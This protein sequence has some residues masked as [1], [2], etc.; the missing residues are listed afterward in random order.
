MA[1]QATMMHLLLLH[2]QSPQASQR[3]FSSYRK[4]PGYIAALSETARLE[5]V[6]YI[7]INRCPANGWVSA[8]W[9]F[10]PTI[11]EFGLQDAHERSGVRSVFC[12]VKGEWLPRCPSLV[13]GPRLGLPDSRF[14][15]SVSLGEF[16][17]PLTACRP[18]QI[19]DDE[20]Q[21]QNQRC[22]RHWPIFREIVRNKCRD[23]RECETGSS[24]RF[25]APL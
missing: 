12:R 16:G 13:Q 22:E 1:M 25:L 2:P 21:Q 4:S 14:A 24:N 5:F 7:F 9:T 18:C 6:S 15:A 17:F 10:A 20:E 3:R 19:R 23:P 8:I 11:G